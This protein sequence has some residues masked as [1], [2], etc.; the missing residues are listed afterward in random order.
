M[1]VCWVMSALLS[2]DYGV[3]NVGLLYTKGYFI[4]YYHQLALLVSELSH[5]TLLLFMYGVEGREVGLSRVLC[6]ANSTHWWMEFVR[7]LP[8]VRG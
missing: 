1:S 4:G 8:A 7:H 5:H 3:L 6:Y 2:R